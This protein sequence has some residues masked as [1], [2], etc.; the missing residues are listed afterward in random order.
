M[1]ATFKNKIKRQITRK[2]TYKSDRFLMD[3]SMVLRLKGM[4]I[5]TTQENRAGAI[6]SGCLK[7]LFKMKQFQNKF[8]MIHNYVIQIQRMYRIFHKKNLDYINQLLLLWEEHYMNIVIYLRELEGNPIDPSKTRL[9]REVE[10]IGHDDED[11]RFQVVTAFY[12]KKKVD[13]TRDLQIWREKKDKLT[14]YVN[15][16]FHINLS[17]EMNLL[18]KMM[19][20]EEKR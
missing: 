1:L 16:P 10:I 19:M 6:I 18:A 7:N 14:N 15:I 2:G 20:K 13:F 11:I 4:L 12:K 9:E 8:V 3:V 5:M 17:K